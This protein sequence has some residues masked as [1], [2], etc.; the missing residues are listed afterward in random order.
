MIEQKLG[1]S[2]EDVIKQRDGFQARLKECG[3]RNV[4]LEAQLNE[5][6]AGHRK[7]E[8]LLVEETNKRTQLEAQLVEAGAR[9][10]RRGDEITNLKFEAGELCVRAEK[11]EGQ[12]DDA[13]AQIVKAEADAARLKGEL[14]EATANLD[15]T[16]GEV[17]RLRA[18]LEQAIFAYG[19]I[20]Q[21]AQIWIEHSGNYG[22]EAENYKWSMGLIMQAREAALT[23][24]LDA[25]QPEG[26]DATRGA[27]EV[28]G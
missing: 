9:I 11:A 28:E 24:E 19:L 22:V 18:A 13:V 12:V 2:L 6:S 3:Q 23:P 20:E 25:R 1:E 16:T 7:V 14:A 5:L 17:F 27:S 26:G 4:E 10:K 21:A 8:D 15:E